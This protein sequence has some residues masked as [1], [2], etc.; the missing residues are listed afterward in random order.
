MKEL[1]PYQLED[2]A[3]LS[4]FNRAACFNE[5]RT[6][7]TPTILAVLR[8]RKLRKVLIVCPASAI[9]PWQDAFIEWNK[10]PCVVL[11]GT[12]KQKQAAL[13]NWTY[14]AVVSFDTLKEIQHKDSR[15]TGLVQTIRDIGCDAIIVD[16]AHRM[17]NPGTATAAAIFKLMHI[18]NRYALT[19]TPTLNNA[20]EI[21][22]ILHWLFPELYRSQYGFY[23]TYFHMLV[24]KTEDREF[25]KIG[26]FKPYMQ[27]VLQEA[28]NKISTQRKRKEVMPWLPDKDYQPIRLPTTIEQ[29]RYIDELEKYYETDHVITE[30]ILDQILRIRQ[31]CLTPALLGLPGQSPKINWI[32]QYLEDYPDRPTL[33]FSKFTQWLQ[34]LRLKIPKNNGIIVGETPKKQRAQYVKDFQSGKLQVLLINIDA[35]KEALT[36]DKAEA[37][38]FTDKFP[39]A[40]DIQQAE[41]RFVSTTIAGK[42]KPHI[43]YELMMTNTYEEKMYKNLQART[44]EISIVNDYQAYLAERKH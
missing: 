34:L 43:I 27:E 13:N 36:L 15:R 6:G 25:Q 21:Y 16:E 7:K 44:A 12:S 30:G 41:D 19:G 33:I 40:G 23:H 39:P 10:R 14:G 22:S 18:P 42:D 9:Y 32:L 29:R 3:F 1:R 24:Q 26:G 5:Q 35:G 11:A 37:I 38:I 31:I 2:V 8:Q 20:Y 28:L 4:Q 17:R